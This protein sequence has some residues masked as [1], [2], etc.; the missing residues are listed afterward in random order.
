MDQ[1]AEGEH[2]PSGVQKSPSIALLGF[3]PLCVPVVTVTSV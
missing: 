3:I 1:A 2:S